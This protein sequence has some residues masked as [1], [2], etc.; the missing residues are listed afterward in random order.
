MKGLGVAVVPTD[1]GQDFVYEVTG[2]LKDAATEAV[3]RS[4]TPQIST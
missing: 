2:G 3:A 4:H 1:L